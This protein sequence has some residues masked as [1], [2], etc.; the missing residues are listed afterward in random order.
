MSRVGRDAAV[1]RG[2]GAA[3]GK[4]AQ[5]GLAAFTLTELLVLVAMGS[6]LT[7]LIL[8]DLSQTR[9]QLL[10]QAC[11]ANLK[12]WGMVVYLYAQDSGGWTY[13]GSTPQSV[14]VS[15]PHNPAIPGG[16]LPYWSANMQVA[17][18]VCPAVASTMTP[19]QLASAS[20]ISYSFTRPNGNTSNGG[21]GAI[22][23]QTCVRIP[24]IPRPDEYALMMDADGQG[25]FVV[26]SGTFYNYTSDILS[27]HQGV[28]NVLFADMHVAQATGSTLLTMRNANTL[29]PWFASQT[30]SNS[31]IVIQYY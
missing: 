13:N 5:K 24:G 1:V 12:H 25:G 14:G 11:I 3:T 17:A 30:P 8:P 21:W 20:S 27:R 22:P 2:N 29:S 26:T 28:V 23:N 15:N 19:T 6:I 31:N 9:S 10:E 18:R 16:Y 4:P 7:G